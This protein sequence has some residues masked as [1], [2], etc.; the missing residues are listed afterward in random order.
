MPKSN[1][2][3]LT[4]DPLPKGDAPSVAVIGGGYWG[5]NLVRN[6]YSLSSLK[7]VCDKNEAL[8]SSL[9]DQYDGLDTCLALSDVLSRSDIAG[10]AIATPAETHFNLARE[11]LLAGKHVYVEKPLVLREHEGQEL[12]EIAQ[13]RDLVLMVGHLLQYHPVFIRLKELTHSGD[14]GRTNYIY[15]NRLNL[16]KIRREENILW[17]FA[18]HDISMILSLAGEEPESLITTGGNYLHKQIADVTTTHMVFPSGLRAHIF[19][20]WLHP[21]KEQ[22]LVV[23]GERKMAVFDDTLPWADKLLLYPHQINWKNNM[24]VPT[25]ADPEKVEIEQQEPLQG[26]CK[27]FLDCMSNGTQPRTDGQ[28]GL[29][30]LEILNASQA[31]LNDHGRKIVLSEAPGMQSEKSPISSRATRYELRANAQGAFIH[32]TA[33]IDENIAIGR[34]TKIWHFSHVLSNSRI[35]KNCNIGQNVVVGPEVS[36]GKGCKIQNNVSVFKGVMLEEGVFCGPSMVFTNIYN[37]RAEIGKM[38]QVRATLVKKGATIGANAT[39]VCGVTLGRY[40]FIGAGAVVNKNI[41]DYALVVGNPARQIGWACECGERLPD[42]LECLTCGKK[43]IK[44]EHGLEP[45]SN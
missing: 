9:K 3:P 43:Y 11:S 12:I 34:G 21:F 16:G 45:I 19:V 23:V 17:S 6:F 22:K 18:P 29:K 41:S 42:D 32:P 33:V 24:P 25:K 40:C 20:S 35:G 8:L 13:K 36:I 4:Y 27:H 7:L 37:P 28:E 10:V 15:S 2:S 26:E 14:L 30:V 5:K 1:P 31:S 38:D 39:I 44:T